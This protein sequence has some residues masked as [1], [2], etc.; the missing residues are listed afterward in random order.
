M[1]DYEKARAENI[2][3]NEELLREIG[4]TGAA[5]RIKRETQPKSTAR[6]PRPKPKPREENVPRR[7]SSRLSGLPAD[8]EVARK[9]AEAEHEALMEQERAKR[10]RVEGPI[11]LV[12]VIQDGGTWEIAKSILADAT[13]TSVK[14]EYRPRGDKTSSAQEAKELASLRQELSSL[15]L[16]TKFHVNDVRICPE[17]IY[18]TTMHPGVTKKLAIAGDKVGY[19]G[20]WDIDNAE[21]KSEGDVKAEEVAEDE[22]GIDDGAGP[23]IHHFKLHSRAISALAFDPINGNQ[24]YSASYDGSVRCLDL[25]SGRAI[26]TFVSEGDSALSQVEVHPDG[27]GLYFSDIQGNVSFKDLRSKD[28]QSFELHERKVGA[29]GMHPMEPHLICTASL[30]RTM[31]VWDWRG[32]SSS[33]GRRKSGGANGPTCLASY[34][35]NLSVSSAFFN[36]AGAVLATAYDDTLCVFDG[37]WTDVGKDVQELTPSTI[38]R[39]NNQTGR[40]LTVFKAHWQTNP[41]DGL[42]KFC[43]GNMKRKVDLFDAKGNVLAELKDVDQVTAV[44]AV[45]EFHPSQNWIVAGNASGKCL[46]WS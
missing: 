1:N 26:E 2:A 43:C 7:T 40:W 45:V 34:T 46:F 20:I 44:P 35:C 42:Q 10:R 4:L 13:S 21:I 5:A 32:A 8:S 23:V 38:V 3:K 28:V 17:R 41:A 39:H 16:H 12:D 9:K 29:M 24:M 30:D 18:C 15:N 27:R 31:K 6:R 25:P 19:L 22:E 11:E 36:S 33:R 37:P 14:R